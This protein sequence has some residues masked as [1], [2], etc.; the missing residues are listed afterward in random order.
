M[1]STSLRQSTLPAA[2]RVVVKLGTQLLARD[3]GGRP[4]IDQAFLGQIAE[5]VGALR[6]G[7]CEVTIVSS[8]AI[9]AG[10]AEMGL[11]E[12]PRDIAQAQALAAVGQRGLMAQFHEAFSS[13]GMH[14]GQVL[15]TRSDFDDRVRFLNIRNTLTHLHDLGCVP[16]LNENDTVA[17]DE[18]RF[19]DNDLLAAMICNA[20]RA[21]ALVLLTV[22]DGLLDEQGQRIE[23]VDD[24][25]AHTRRIG[26]DTSTWGS[27]GMHSKL[28][29]ARRVVEAGELAI[30]AAGRERNVLP[31]LLAGEPLGTVFTPRQRKLDSRQ[32][33]IGLTARAAGTITVDQ[34]AAH[35][36]SRHNKSLLATGITDV[37]GGFDRGAIVRVRD[38]AGREIAR[39]LSNYSGHELKL[40][41]G[42]RSDEFESILGRS[43]YDE[44]IHR[45]NLV[46]RQ[47]DNAPPAEAPGSSGL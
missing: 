35:A 20:L 37:A 32:R 36:L 24:P 30:I 15:L 40:I 45:D 7:G 6:D 14:V 42:K 3:A 2:R 38:A 22:V 21:E 17:V 34:G 27:G 33:W 10:C 9:G 26:R 5:Q 28:E 47:A 29:A 13:R 8:G 44:V 43:A 46:V 4:G 1:P 23:L 39:G 31:R 19:G 12:R 18:I 41:Q 11:T 25:D 16:V